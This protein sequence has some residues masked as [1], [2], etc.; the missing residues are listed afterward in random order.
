VGFLQSVLLLTAQ[1]EVEPHVV[2]LKGSS[3]RRE[4]I[5]LLVRKFMTENGCFLVQVLPA[6]GSFVFAQAVMTLQ[7]S[8]TPT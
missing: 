6:A 5:N 8:G 3:V 7:G 1:R 2:A 4:Q